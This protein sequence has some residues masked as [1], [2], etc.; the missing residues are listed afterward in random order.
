MKLN[1]VKYNDLSDGRYEKTTYVKTWTGRTVSLE[2]DLIRAEWE[3]SEKTTRSKG[4]NPERTTSI[5]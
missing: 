4:R 5:S 3:A 2:T 1:E